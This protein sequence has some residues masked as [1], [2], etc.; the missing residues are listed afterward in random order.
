MAGRFSIQL[1]RR[2]A[3]AA[4]LAVAVSTATS[5]LAAQPAGLLS[6]S[7][8]GAYLNPSKNQEIHLV[9]YNR[10]YCPTPCPCDPNGYSAEGQ[11]GQLGDDPARATDSEPLASA[12]LQAEQFGGLGSDTMTVN[13]AIGGYIDNPVVGNWFRARYD[14]AVN[15]PHPDLAEF[16]YAKYA[17]AGGPGVTPP[18]G[19]NI[20]PTQTNYQVGT[21]YLEW[22]LAPRLSVFAELAVQR[23]DIFFPD[24][25]NG[26]VIEKNGGLGDTIAGFK[27]ALL[28]DD[29]QYLTFQFKTYIPTGDSH[30]G[31]GTHHTSL[32]PGLLYLRRLNCR[33]YFQGELRY[34]I[35]I[36]GTD[37][38]GNIIR[39]GAGLGYDIWNSNGSSSLNPYVADG[40]RVTAVGEFVGWS[41]LNGKF[42]PAN[43]VGSPIDGVSVPDGFTVV[44][45]KP[46]FRFTHNQGS[47]YAGA[48]IAMTGDRWYS[49]LFRIEYR[50][51]F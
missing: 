20:S 19:L 46:G 10:P 36:D 39:Y 24:N 51:M 44:N 33:T 3:T 14:V 32:E 28:T 50:R 22:M 49:D 40:W 30:R 41:V 21:F 25:S 27:Y 45:V 34:W 37:Y 26:T 18:P 2:V 11:P 5:A 42:T 16:F 43:A 48:G 9:G 23:T 17:L 12:N 6:F 38:A 13:D 15:N 1:L 29:I 4:S 47:L 35:P 8:I 7:G 31:L